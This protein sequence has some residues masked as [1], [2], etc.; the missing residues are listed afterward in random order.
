MRVDVRV[1]LVTDPSVVHLDRLVAAAVTGGVTCVQLRD[2]MAPPAARLASVRELRV[3][4]RV[5]LL[6]DD[7]LEAA[8]AA[9]GLHV[10]LDDV[11]P[12]VARAALGAAAIIGWS[13]ED[14]AQLDDGAQL[15]ACDYVAASPVWT[16]PTK[17]GA[18]RPLGLAGVRELAGRLGGQ[19]PL[20]AIGGID[21][22]NAA[23]VIAAG[24]DG[25]AVV[26]A[27][28]AAD[29]PAAAARA[30]RETVDAALAQRSTS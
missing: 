5:P 19:M 17:A 1:Y 3:A 22:A 7:D 14:P 18:D 6:V 8:A 21:A 28:C 15:A 26:R 23:G 20:V 2:K 12:T 13:V 30:L 24:A 11:R 10:G 29:D 27:I 25:V 16:T 4:A 9:D